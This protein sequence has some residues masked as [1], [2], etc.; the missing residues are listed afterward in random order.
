MGSDCMSNEELG[1]HTQFRREVSQ[2]AQAPSEDA[3]GQLPLNPQSVAFNLTH[4]V[5]LRPRS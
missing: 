4:G 1:Y 3:S 2:Q 5:Y